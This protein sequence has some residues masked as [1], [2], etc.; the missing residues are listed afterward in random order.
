MRVLHRLTPLPGF[1]DADISLQPL[2]CCFPGLGK[3]VKQV[4]INNPF[5]ASL[6]TCLPGD[7]S[8]A[9]EIHQSV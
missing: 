6:E 1:V 5:E 3:M 8:F 7:S 4:R 2:V 9:F